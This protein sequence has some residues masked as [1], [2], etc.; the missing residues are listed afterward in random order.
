MNLKELKSNDTLVGVFISDILD[1]VYANETL[2]SL[3]MQEMPVD[4]LILVDPKMDSEK[5]AKLSSI[6]ENPTIRTTKTDEKTGQKEPV[7]L[8]AGKS[9]CYSLEEFSPNNF[10]DIFNKIFQ[11]SVENK[12]KYMSIIEFEDAFSLRWFNTAISFAEENKSYSIFAPLLKYV[13]SGAFQ[14]YMNELC[15]VEG[16]SEEVGKYDNNMFLKFNFALNPLGSLYCV[17]RLL[18]FDGMIEVSGDAHFPMKSSI[19]L[20]SFW[21]FMIRTTYNGAKIMNVPR[22]GYELRERSM[23]NYDHRSVKIPKNV[24]NISVE[25]GG[26][27]PDEARFWS[28][29]ATDSYFMENDNKDIRYEPKQSEESIVTP[30]EGLE[31]RAD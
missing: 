14:S 15:W 1:E 19:K 8:Q 7:I 29:Y 22:I 11:S 10:A 5:R 25:N 18:E 12:Y 2:Y 9:L 20:F 30:A 21:E 13:S 27:S 31:E 3:A 16:M 24:I 17:D 4:V 28:K 6:I 26:I 23:D